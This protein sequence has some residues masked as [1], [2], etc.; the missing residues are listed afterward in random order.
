MIG[1][2][3]IVYWSEDVQE[4]PQDIFA[5]GIDP[6]EDDNDLLDDVFKKM[7]AGEPL[8]WR[9]SKIDSSIPFYV[10]GLAPNAARVSVRFFLRDS[11]GKILTNL[12]THYQRLEIDKG[13]K[14]FEYLSV[15]WMLREILS[16]KISKPEPPPLLAGAVMRTIL[17]N[18]PYP[19]ELYSGVLGRIR[20][21]QD[22]PDKHIWKVTRGRAAI[23]K[24]CLLKKNLS[25]KDRE[26]LTV[27]LNEH[28]NNR[29]YVLGRLFAVLEKAQEDANPDVNTT[30][31]NR[32]FTSACA[33]PGMVFPTLLKLSQSHIAKAKYGYV[34][35]RKVGELM[36]K[37]TDQAPFPA[38]LNLEDQGLFILGYY[39]QRQN[40][41]LKKVAQ[42]NEPAKKEEE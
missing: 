28:S 5:A 32:F 23:I 29:A 38:R 25:P 21:E 14:E 39:H 9:G 34:N 35:E 24:A 8:N 4:A 42:E 16:S 10:L 1:D 20:S 17:L 7:A 15:Y 12:K 18:L 27:S 33:T 37:L 6:R 2:T 40:R 19:E 30:I 11:F 26:V 36:E 3:S 41:F 13:P 31:K 22:D